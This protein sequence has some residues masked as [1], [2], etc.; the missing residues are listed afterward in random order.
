MYKTLKELR[1]DKNERI[2]FF[3]EENLEDWRNISQG[4]FKYMEKFLNFGS[5][6]KFFLAPNGLE[7]T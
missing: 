7:L 3:K 6:A 2:T 1:K 4:Y 5:E